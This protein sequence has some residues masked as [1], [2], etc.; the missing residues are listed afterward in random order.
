M[1]QEL[2]SGDDFLSTGGSSRQ[3]CP[4]MGVGRA[5]LVGLQGSWTPPLRPHREAGSTPCWLLRW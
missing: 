4:V 2:L 5:G 3:I 1:A